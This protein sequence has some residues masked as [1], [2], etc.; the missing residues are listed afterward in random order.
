MWDPL[1]VRLTLP[2]LR[3]SRLGSLCLIFAVFGAV[4]SAC[5]GE[6]GGRI[7]ALVVRASDGLTFVHLDGAASGK[8]A[9]ATYDYWMIKADA[10]L[11]GK[12]QYAALLGAKLSGKTVRIVGSNLCTRWGDGED[13]DS[14]FVHD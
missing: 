11:A 7:T 13:I 3:A 4:G 5:A 2:C 10:S 9:C 6:Q 1:P 14:L 12:Q 8:P